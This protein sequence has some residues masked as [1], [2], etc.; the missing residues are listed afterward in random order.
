[1]YV[2][3]L[4]QAALHPSWRFPYGTWHIYIEYIFYVFVDVVAR[5]GEEVGGSFGMIG[6]NKRL[7]RLFFDGCMIDTAVFGTGGYI[8]VVV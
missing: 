4:L 2:V 6:V 3:K 5:Y 8:I 1:M 7:H